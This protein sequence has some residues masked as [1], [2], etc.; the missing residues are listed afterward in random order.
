[1]PSPLGHNRDDLIRDLASELRPQLTLDVWGS[2]VKGVLRTANMK[3]AN[4]VQSLADS[5][6]KALDD[7]R[8]DPHAK[9][10]V[11]SAMDRKSPYDPMYGP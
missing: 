7:V 5:A 1:M 6:C 8:L 10:H 9:M 4:D 3:L 2:V 11:F